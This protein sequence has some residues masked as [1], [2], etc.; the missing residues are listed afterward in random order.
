MVARAS[1]EPAR[2]WD[3]PVGTDPEQAERI[4]QSIGGAVPRASALADIARSL[5]GA[6]QDE[7]WQ[8]RGDYA[9]L[10]LMRRLVVP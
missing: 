7:V 2:R 5:S 1:V 4:A 8:P 10:A 3:V 9:E 6:Q